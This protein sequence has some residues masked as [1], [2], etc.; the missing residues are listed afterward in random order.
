MPLPSRPLTGRDPHEQGRAATSLELLY[1]LTFVVAIGIAGEHFAELIAEGH[2]GTAGLGF[3]FA[4]FAIIKTWLDFSWF[5]SAFDTDDWP[6]RALVMVQMIG[7]VVIALGV[8]PMYESLADKG[9]HFDFQTI[10]VGYVIIRLAQLALWFR[11]ARSSKTYSSSAQRSIVVMGLT[12]ALWTALALAAPPVNVAVPLVLL[13]GAGE[14]L[15]PVFAQRKSATGTPWHPH[16]IAE[17]YS[18]LAIIAL[19]EGV[20]G[21]V[22]STGPASGNIG[23]WD[24]TTIALIVAGIGITFGMWWAYFQVPFGE[25]LHNAPTRGFAFG[26]GHIPVFVAIA[27]V[28]A[29]L[30]LAGLA[31]GDSAHG[32][33]HETGVTALTVALCVAIP[34]AIFTIGVTLIEFVLRGQLKRSTILGCAAALIIAMGACLLADASLGG[35]LVLLVG[36]AFAPVFARAR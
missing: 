2:L 1:D 30:H 28:G 10:T 33:H 27:A 26:Y 13:L 4:M 15:T 19:G 11:V 23:S 20:V 7:V 34:L 31:G 22:A 35:A 8:A 21:T 6:F 12:T 18:L 14:L 25:L 32:G 29:G 5:S 17:R 3:A 36:A 16:H 24:S 9:D